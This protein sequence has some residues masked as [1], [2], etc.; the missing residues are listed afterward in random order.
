MTEPVA[1]LNK[2]STYRHLGT[3]LAA[4]LTA[5][6]PLISSAQEPAANGGGCRL[7]SGQVIATQA[8]PN[9]PDIAAASFDRLTGTPIIYFN[10]RAVSRLP[11]AFREFVHAHE[12]A[13][14]HLDHLR[15][16][17]VGS[18]GEAEADCWAAAELTAQGV[19]SP[20]DIA[21][22]SKVLAALLPGDRTHLSG[23]L[24][25]SELQRCVRYARATTFGALAAAQ[26]D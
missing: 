4:L 8:T 17:W 24:R 14:H 20:N 7:S 18:A 5:C 15:S 11:A 26:A 16:G 6:T 22:I 13:H 25:A 19:L 21:I 23:H 10:P 12:C 9:L 3:A 1:F 2:K